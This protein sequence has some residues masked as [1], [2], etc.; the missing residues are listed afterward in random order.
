MCSGCSLS[1]TLLART[2]PP[3]AGQYGCKRSPCFPIIFLF[4]CNTLP[5][6]SKMLPLSW[7]QFLAPG[8]W[9]K[10]SVTQ[11]HSHGG[12]TVP[13]PASQPCCP[14]AAQTPGDVFWEESCFD[15]HCAKGEAGCRDI[16]VT[17]PGFNPTGCLQWL[18]CRWKA[19]LKLQV[20]GFQG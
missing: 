18:K 7:V 13:L 9:R 15:K 10:G 17:H 8:P 14:Q 16:R 19:R 5:C 3:M 2:K 20:W 6:S 1:L 12:A 11:P 4:W